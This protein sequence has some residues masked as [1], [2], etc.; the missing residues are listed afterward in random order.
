MPAVSGAQGR[1]GAEWHP[2]NMH[3]QLIDDLQRNKAKRGLDMVTWMLSSGFGRKSK[4]EV[5]ASIHRLD[6]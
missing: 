6:S 1:P 2:L 3:I 5:L 4:S